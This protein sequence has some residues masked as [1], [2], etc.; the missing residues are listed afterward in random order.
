MA[1]LCHQGF[2]IGGGLLHGVVGVVCQDGDAS[3]RIEMPGFVSL[4]PGRLQSRRRL[5]E[6]HP[7]E[8]LIHVRPETGWANLVLDK[9]LWFRVG[10][11]GQPTNCVGAAVDDQTGQDE[12][13]KEHP[14]GNRQGIEAI[15]VVGDDA[16]TRKKHIASERDVEESQVPG[17][18]PAVESAGYE[19]A[20]QGHKEVE[21]PGC[22]CLPGRAGVED[23]EEDTVD[24]PSAGGWWRWWLRRR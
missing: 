7:H 4:A 14:P 16:D 12:Q 13:G 2:K 24:L 17:V 10:G 19:E 11:K 6:G 9:W 15:E 8:L 23:V 18:E 20:H 5:A 3:K 21:H 22:E 1:R